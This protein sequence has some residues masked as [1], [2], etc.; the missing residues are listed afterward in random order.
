MDPPIPGCPARAFVTWRTAAAVWIRH[1]CS[2]TV[3]GVS[4][5]WA[6][7]DAKSSRVVSWQ[8]G[9]QLSASTST[10]ASDSQA[11]LANLPPCPFL[12]PQY[13]GMQSGKVGVGTIMSRPTQ[14]GDRNGKAGR[15]E[16]QAIMAACTH[17]EGSPVAGLPSW[18]RAWRDCGFPRAARTRHKKMQTK[19]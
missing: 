19:C 17:Q 13:S 9:W 15:R 14:K 18:M 1:D 2:S 8:G 10:A 6:V 12:G 16:C 3:L 11:L 7:D 5:C 4:R